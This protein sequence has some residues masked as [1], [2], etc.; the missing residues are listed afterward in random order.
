MDLAVAF[1]DG[2]EKLVRS[3]SVL[4]LAVGTECAYQ[5]EIA[6]A[7]PDTKMQIA[8][9]TLAQTIAPDTVPVTARRTSVPATSGTAAT[10]A[11]SQ[12]VQISAVGTM[13]SVTTGNVSV[14]K[15]GLGRIALITLVLST[16][17]VTE[18]VTIL[19]GSARAIT[20][21]TVLA[22]SFECA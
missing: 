19:A 15:G 12:C 16:A 2:K 22:A 3:S 4:G 1:M 18:S 7:M 20:F 9:C 17:L 11:H 14:L 6:S 8:A 10:I 21:T 13:A 5:L